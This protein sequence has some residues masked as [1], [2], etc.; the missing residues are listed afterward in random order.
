MQTRLESALESA[1][2]IG[3]GFLISWIVTIYF[4][5]WWFGIEV[6][7]HEAAEVTCVYTAISV[8][9]SYA[10]RR[11]FNKRLKLD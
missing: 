5:P 9:R 6:R 11:A 2:N 4:L 10:W 8:L 7:A 3:S 1:F